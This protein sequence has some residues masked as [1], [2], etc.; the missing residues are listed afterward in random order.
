M[1]GVLIGLLVAMTP[2]PALAV[3]P[4]EC[5]QQRAQ[6]PRDWNDVSNEKPL[7]I[8]TSHYGGAV[9]VT[10]G[11]AADEGRWLMSVVPVE[12]NDAQAKQKSGEDVY[13]IWLDREQLRHLKAGK[14]FAT[15]L[16]QQNSCWIRGSLSSDHSDS[17]IFFMDNSDPAPDDP[18]KAGSFYNKAPRFSVFHGNAYDC[19]SIK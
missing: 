2:F 11:K 7:F 10:I 1:R 19:K 5:E 17:T 12:G 4:D 9:K 14:Y 8:C 6:Y 18:A 15:V 16:R 13:R 3:R